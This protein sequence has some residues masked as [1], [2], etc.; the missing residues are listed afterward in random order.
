MV[1]YDKPEETLGDLRTFLT[2]VM[3]YGSSADVA[4]VEQYVQEEEFRRGIG[5]CTG[6]SVY[7]GSLEE[8]A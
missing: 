6:W 2:H 1:W 3:V 8:V 4:V 5:E 7:A